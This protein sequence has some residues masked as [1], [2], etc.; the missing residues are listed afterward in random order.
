MGNFQPIIDAAQEAVK[1][2]TFE[3]HGHHYTRRELIRIPKPKPDYT[4]ALTLHS[5]AGLTQYFN[6]GLDAI[7]KLNPFFHVASPTEVC[8]YAQTTGREESRQLLVK[9]VFAPARF[10]TGKALDPETFNGL[11]QSSFVPGAGDYADVLRYAA[12]IVKDDAVEI[13][14]DSVSQSV[15][16]KRGVRRTHETIK[17]PV[18]LAPYR[19]FAEVAQPES[20]HILRVTA[21][22]D[23][24]LL[25]ADNHA[26]ENEARARIAEFLAGSLPSEITIIV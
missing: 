14:D 2:E 6:D 11:F 10:P 3:F 13:A 16:L 7:D 20:K 9:A 26:W 5:L 4:P 17:N 15:T 8:V 19:T 24:V 21:D 23:F 25:E 18:T 1:N 22:L 12:T